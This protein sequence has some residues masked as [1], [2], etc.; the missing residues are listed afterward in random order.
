V[1]SFAFQSALSKLRIRRL[2]NL[3][4]GAYGGAHFVVYPNG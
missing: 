4:G 3:S 2:W 1:R